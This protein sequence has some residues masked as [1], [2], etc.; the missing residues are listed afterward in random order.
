[1]WKT[2]RCWG[3]PSCSTA[4]STSW[5]PASSG[6]R[7][8]HRSTRTQLDRPTPPR[9]LPRPARDR[10]QRPRPHQ[11]RQT[12]PPS[13]RRRPRPGRRVHG[14]ARRPARALLAY[15]TEP[16]SPTQDTLHQLAS[17]PRPAPT[18]GYPAPPGTRSTLCRPQGPTEGQALA[19]R[20]C[21]AQRETPPLIGCERR[22]RLASHA[23][24]LAK[25]RGGHVRNALG[26]YRSGARPAG[27]PIAALRVG[28][29]ERSPRGA[30]SIDKRNPT[31]S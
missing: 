27:R 11:R 15:T 12:P 19:A 23:A 5:P 28:Q 10:A 3:V 4:D 29:G 24:S 13:R 2:R 18:S 16:G 21:D 17:R 6:L 9:R 14:P 8:T 26:R 30:A 22:S 31:V 1:M 7:C 20:G 25:P